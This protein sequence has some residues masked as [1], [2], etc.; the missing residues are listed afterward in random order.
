MVP[1]LFFARPT[2]EALR[3][4]GL[5][6]IGFVLTFS[7]LIVRNYLV[8][9]KFMATRG[10]FWHSF[11]A[12]VGQTPNPYNVRDDDETI[13]R[14]AKTLDSTAQYETDHYEQVLKR[15][16]VTLIKDH[17][18][19]YVGSVAKRTAV[20]IFP[21]IG[22]ELFFQ[23]QLPQH[24]SGTMNVSFGK[25]FLLLVDGL[26]TGLFLAGIWITRKRWKDLL[27]ICFPYYYT[28]LSLAPFYLTGRNI[29]NVYFVV[30]LLASVAIAHFWSRLRPSS[31]HSS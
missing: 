28:L 13:I 18:L 1:L 11:W 6:L 17:T 27:V 8:F 3:F 5:L 30:L 21:K 12:G 10:V 7:P 25:V 19:W 31:L 20:F 24:I 4:S 14:F 2:K 22:R 29:M 26:L 15:K 23:P 9:D 16:A